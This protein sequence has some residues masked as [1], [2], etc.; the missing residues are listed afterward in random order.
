MREERGKERRE[1]GRQGGRGRK[2]GTR[3]EGN[4]EAGSMPEGIGC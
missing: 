2:A 1:G 3:E 4:L